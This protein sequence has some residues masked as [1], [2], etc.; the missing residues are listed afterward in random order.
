MSLINLIEADIHQERKL[1]DT[2]WKS[3]QE[4]IRWMEKNNF[5]KLGSGAFAA[6]YAVPGHKRVVRLSLAA[7]KC[8]THFA[9]WAMNITSNPHLPR[10]Q[11]TKWYEG[12][13]KGKQQTFV[14]SIVE[15]LERFDAQ[16][17]AGT[18]DFI[19]LVELYMSG[20]IFEST[21][22]HMIEIRLERE[23]FDPTTKR[24][25][26]KIELYRQR[27]QKSRFSSTLNAV[28]QMAMKTGCEYDFHNENL[29][30][31]PQTKN[32]VL[33]DPLA[34]FDSLTLDD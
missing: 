23:G 30:Y 3:P 32:I 34:D 33:I 9:D 8:W 11:W 28:H 2:A 18:T 6:A 19:A 26:D 20:N 21:I 7:D 16:A 1:R 13:R 4:A 24:G 12:T 31:R 29:M 22:E 10:I 15:R 17:I 25:R 14:L 5:Q 27:H